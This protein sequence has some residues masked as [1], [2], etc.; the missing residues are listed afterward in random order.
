VTFGFIHNTR[1]E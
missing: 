1:T